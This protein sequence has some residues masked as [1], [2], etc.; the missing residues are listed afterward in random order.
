MG[1]KLQPGESVNVIVEAKDLFGGDPELIVEKGE[2]YLFE[3]PENQKWK[4]WCINTNADGF[5]NPL[6]LISGR[7]VKGVRC[8][9]LCG[10]IGKNEDYHF[11]I[12]SFLENYKIPISGS[13]YFFPNDS[14]RHYS[15]NSG[16]ILVTVTRIS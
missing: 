2:Y 8:F 10:T 16:A 13:L 3:V 7:R 11:K 14:I 9:T 1:L 12:G 6:L 4:D 15:N 5:I